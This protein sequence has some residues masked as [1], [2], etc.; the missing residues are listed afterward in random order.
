[1][2]QGHC[3]H[4]V[5]F[6]D[7][8]FFDPQR[9]AVSPE[10]GVFSEHAPRR[11]LCP[12]CACRAADIVTLNDAPAEQT[13]AIW[14]TSCYKAFHYDATT[15]RLRYG[16][17]EAYRINNSTLIADASL[18]VPDD[19]PFPSGRQDIGTLWPLPEEY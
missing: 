3:E 6:G 12:Y 10:L 19:P 13:P 8:R 5:V 15:H 16:D 14:C 9:S 4:I 17:F 7:V 11:R 2:H 18:D 1:M